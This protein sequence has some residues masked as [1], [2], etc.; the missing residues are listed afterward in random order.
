MIW[1]I[2]IGV[3]LVVT[4]VIVISVCALSARMSQHE[5]WSETPIMETRGETT[6]VRDYQTDAATSI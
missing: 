5:E 2:A 1:L 4:A 6:S 3:Y